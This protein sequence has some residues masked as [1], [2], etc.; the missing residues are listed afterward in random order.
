MNN[1][2]TIALISLAAWLV[3][4]IFRELNTNEWK[5]A[6]DKAIE[7]VEVGEEFYSCDALYEASKHCDTLCAKYKRFLKDNYQDSI[8]AIDRSDNIWLEKDYQTIGNRVHML[9]RFRET[10]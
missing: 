3:A 9:K 6:V 7:T 4:V 1:I 8:K 5:I 10:L 2:I